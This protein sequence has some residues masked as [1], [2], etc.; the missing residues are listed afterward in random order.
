M[1]TVAGTWSF[2][3]SGFMPGEGLVH[4]GGL[5]T[6]NAT[7]SNVTVCDYDESWNCVIDTTAGLTL[8]ARTDGG[9][10]LNEPGQSGVAQLYGYKAPN[11]TLAVFGTT[12]AAGANG[13]DVTQTTIV[14]TKQNLLAVPALNT[15]SK[16]WDVG[17]TRVGVTTTVDAPMTDSNTVISV[18]GSTVKRKRESDGREDTVHYNSP[19]AGM[20]TRDAG[21]WNSVGFGKAYQVPMQGLGVV[22]SV[23]AV[24]A[25]SGA[26]FFRHISVIRP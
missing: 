21:V 16:F 24:P 10:D 23:N 25:S 14:G 2:V 13:T 22:L 12:N 6:L 18:D 19:V 26:A 9:F 3:Q 4:S 1:A 5:L 7:N 20:R 15:L 8:S 11:G 17:Y